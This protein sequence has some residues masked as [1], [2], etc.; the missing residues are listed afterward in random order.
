MKGLKTWRMGRA[1]GCLL[2]ASLCELVIG[3]GA[4]VLLLDLQRDPKALVELPDSV[5]LSLQLFAWGY[6]PAGV[7]T[8]AVA[9]WA[10][11]RGGTRAVQTVATLVL[12]PYA[13][14]Y[15][16]LGLVLADAANKDQPG[17]WWDAVLV[18]AGAAA[19]CH[20]VGTGLLFFTG[21]NR[22]RDGGA[23]VRERGRPGP[24]WA[25]ACLLVA[26]VC[27]LLVAAGS[28]VFLPSVRR[29][30]AD[31]E[32]ALDGFVVE[33]AL[34]ALQ[35]QLWVYAAAG[36]IALALAAL[37]WLRGGTPGVR[38]AVALAVAPYTMLLLYGPWAGDGLR[39]EHVGW[40]AD[41]PWWLSLAAGI[42]YLVGTILLVFAK[43]VRRDGLLVAAETGS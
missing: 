15:L 31:P 38:T 43:T 9:A 16:F 25:V 30:A 22:P 18:L 17:L 32:S 41:F 23:A 1:A 26:S 37:V 42:C 2:A 11:W 8:L 35:A 4:L 13:P 29:R 24:G 7:I 14:F 12:A 34:E 27:G 10:W 6:T 33:R 36:V 3:I 5:P 39:E 21:P 19:L 28:L 40:Y 20:L